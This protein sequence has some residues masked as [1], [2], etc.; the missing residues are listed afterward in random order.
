MVVSAERKNIWGASNRNNPEVLVGLN[1]GY[2]SPK[3]TIQ[4]ARHV[5]RLGLTIISGDSTKNVL[6]WM[7]F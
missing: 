5:Q 2:L 3:I 7:G 4:S 6:E 1:M